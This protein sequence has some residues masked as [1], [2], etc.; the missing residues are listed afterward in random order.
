[1]DENCNEQELRAF[2]HEAKQAGIKELILD[3][4]YRH[5]IPS[6]EVLR[7][8]Q[9][10]KYLIVLGGMHVRYGFTGAQFTPEIDVATEI[11]EWP[12]MTR[13]QRWAYRL[14]LWHINTSGKYRVRC[15][16]N[17]FYTPLKRLIKHQQ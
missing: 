12:D 9:Q 15:F 6:R 11:N 5:P 17:R 16:L 8:L 2:V 1:M 7:G 13:A 3:I 14:K 10:L 4:D